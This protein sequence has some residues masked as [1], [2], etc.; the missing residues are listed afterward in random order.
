MAVRGNTLNWQ[1]SPERLNVHLKIQTDEWECPY[2]KANEP[3]YEIVVYIDCSLHKA[4]K[5]VG[6][7]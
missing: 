6:T 3:K 7:Q 2:I 5:Q 1:F 4:E